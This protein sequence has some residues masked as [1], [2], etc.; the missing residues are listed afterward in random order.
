MI[1]ATSGAAIMCQST[2]F[3]VH[4][5]YSSLGSVLISASRPFVELRISET[6]KE[7]A[8]ILEL[9]TGVYLGGTNLSELVHITLTGE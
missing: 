8:K 2:H 3:S 5:G 9:R 1:F 7:N 6:P 4:W